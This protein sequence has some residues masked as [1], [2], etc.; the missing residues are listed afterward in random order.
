[1]N[2]ARERATGR[3]M[4]HVEIAPLGRE[5]CRKGVKDTPLDRGEPQMSHIVYECNC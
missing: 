1:V 5:W 4:K 2:P 3:E